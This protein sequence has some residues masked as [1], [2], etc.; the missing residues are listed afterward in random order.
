MSGSSAEAGAGAGA[1]GAG[2][3]SRVLLLA[4]DGADDLDFFGAWSV[5]A[6]AAAACATGPGGGLSA[7]VLAPGGS[8]VTSGGLRVG[9]QAVPPEDAPDAVVLPGGP[10]VAAAGAE[11]EMQARLRRW[12]AGGT[13]FYTICSGALLLAAAGLL[14]RKRVAIHAA[15]RHLLPAGAEAASGLQQDGW[16]TSCGGDVGPRVKSVMIG[17]RAVEDFC[18]DQVPALRRRMEIAA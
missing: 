4:Y 9:A 16:L 2:P 13:R 3:R 14:D 18:S 12:R 6:K 15:K 11:A 1:G 5:L 17:F 10:G 8:F 7:S